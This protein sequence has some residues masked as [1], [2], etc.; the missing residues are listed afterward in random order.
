MDLISALPALLPE[1][2][3][4]AE[5]QA[6]EALA[7]G[8]PLGAEALENARR[9]GVQNPERIRVKLVGALPLPENPVLKAAAL[10]GGLLGP[11]RIGLT[12]GYAVFIVNGTLGLR[13]LSHES[14]HVYQYEQHGGIASFLPIY[15]AEVVSVGYFW[16]SFEAD[17]QA[18]EVGPA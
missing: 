16:S 13:V 9:V 2:I 18:H 4:W 17:A 10:Q 12:L 11:D 3:A 1:A 5:A 8:V 7:T 14:R 15:L 6:A